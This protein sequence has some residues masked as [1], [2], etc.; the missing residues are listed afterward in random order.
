MMK[1]FAYPLRAAI[2][3][4]RL[5]VLAQAIGAVCLLW[6]A[7]GVVAEPSQTPLLQR[8]ESNP[9][10]N[11]LFSL[12]DSGSMTHQYVP[13]GKF[14]VNDTELNFPKDARIYMHPLELAKNIWSKNGNKTAPQ[15][16]TRFVTAVPQS[17]TSELT[18][19]ERRY[20][21]QMRSPQ[22]NKLY[23]NPAFVYAPW[24]GIR[25]SN[26]PAGSTA[27]FQKGDPYTFTAATYTAAKLDPMALDQET[28]L[29]RN[30]D[31]THVKVFGTAV[32]LSEVKSY[33][34]YWSNKAF[35]NI[36][37]TTAATMVNGNIV[38]ANVSS[39]LTSK[40]YNPGLV[41]VLRDGG[42]PT[43]LSDYK[44][45]NLNATATNVVYDKAYSQ[46][47]ELGGCVANADNKT[48]CPIDVERQ[49]FANWFVFYRSR[50]MAAQGGIPAALNDFDRVFRFGW[51]TLRPGVLFDTKDPDND[52]NITKLAKSYLDYNKDGGYYTVD[53]G[54]SATVQYG[55]RDWEA[56]RKR[57]FMQWLRSLNTWGGTPT[58]QAVYSVGEYFKRSSPWLSD[59]SVGDN[60]GGTELSCRR[61]YHMVMTDGYYTE[62]TA[63]DAA[64]GNLDGAKKTDTAGA[65]STDYLYPTP[66][67]DGAGD[68]LA[69]YVMKYWAT[70][71]RANT[72]NAVNPVTVTPL[73]DTNDA[74]AVAEAKSDPA[75][76]QH[77][78]HFFLGFGVT[79]NKLSNAA[80][81]D[82]TAYDQ[83]LLKMIHCGQ[84]GG[85]CWDDTNVDRVD[86][87][88]HASLNGRGSYFSVNN[89]DDV[90]NAVKSIVRSLNPY[91]FKEAGV[92]TAS[93]S[94]QA[95]NVKFVPEY[96]PQS[97][98]ID[99]DEYWT[100]DVVAW[101][102]DAKGVAAATPLWKAS[103]SLPAPASRNIK[104]LD[105]NT[106]VDFK[107]ETYTAL[108]ADLI[109]FVRGERPS[110]YFRK[111]QNL[112]PDFI[113]ST[114]LFINKGN[115]LGYGSL[116]TPFTGSSTY[117][118][119]LLGTKATTG[120]ARNNDG[121]A[122]RNDGLL[123]VGGNGGMLHAFST[124]TGEE[125]FAYVPRGAQENQSLLSS[126]N[127]GSSS[128]YH[129]FFVDG[130]L[131]E[132]DAYFG[133]KWHNIVVGTL[134][135]GGRG[136]FALDLKPS[137]ISGSDAVD[138]LWD[139]KPTPDMG[140][141]TSTPQVGR[142]ADGSW[143]VFIG[144]GVDS[145]NNTPS[146]TVI[147]LATGESQAIAVGALPTSTAT[148][149]TTADN[150][151][152]SSKGLGGVTL[153]RDTNTGNVQAI[154]AG[155][156]DGRLW[157]F[158][159]I[160]DGAAGSTTTSIKAAFG[161]VP[162]FTA[163]D[164]DS[165]GKPQPILAA[166]AIFAHPQGG[167]VIVVNTGKL[168]HEGDNK[169]SQQLQSV[170]GIWDQQPVATDT[171]T[172][173]PPVIGRNDL[174]H[175]LIDKR[176]D[177]PQK[178]GPSQAFFQLKT[179][180][181]DWNSQQGW[182]LDLNVPLTTLANTGY[183]HPKAIYD[184]VIFRNSVLI[185]AVSPGST[186]ETC[187][188]STGLG[189][190]LL[191]KGLTGVVSSV[192]V[193]DT[194]GDGVV[195]NDDQSGV[196]GL[197]YSGGRSTILTDGGCCGTTNPPIPPSPNDCLNG[198]DQFADG[199]RAIRDC[200]G[201]RIQDR[202]WRQLLN[203]PQVTTVD[204]S[205][206]GTGTGTTSTTTSTSTSTATQ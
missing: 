196:G 63:K 27:S 153:V 156:T 197:T 84:A 68:T 182:L 179:A 53:G 98:A 135:A 18:D 78:N 64:V 31:D 158:D 151:T 201:L 69:D 193:I 6:H 49:N 52:P 110:V 37:V 204:T 42:D 184:P 118:D 113:N 30:A 121:K 198:S 133:D 61:A 167:Q 108:D 191:L 122:S 36:D 66:F 71:L 4:P 40:T 96:S 28:P 1:T 11:F 51:G 23:Y 125:R 79:A 203:P 120:A 166:P 111:R 50:L 136:I 41:Y 116:K 92:A 188:K 138:V 2:T 48:S 101:S 174:Q 178:T 91:P 123:F 165:G 58:R 44:E 90:K 95:G 24:P 73:S 74:K 172:M 93:A 102:L 154:Y 94:L 152:A 43:V 70:D 112:L 46:R 76:W 106:L 60:V 21:Y 128:N 87:L 177:L 130:Q 99:F 86:D 163:T 77:L 168:L 3:A 147:D 206:T 205:K 57:Q 104:V 145:D 20:Q 144:N 22:V 39:I 129:H 173:T 169:G 35:N 146:L 80:L 54:S 45:F 170:Y 199:S 143:R 115:D 9:K 159:V 142:L 192:P 107:P 16:D 109:R 97:K 185:N 5:R 14:F 17:V 200:G 140:Y 13:E 194:N 117:Q 75:T 189:Y 59:P 33:T 127:Y 148:T 67:H 149:S 186:E 181:V 7:G 180:K 141:M 85:L 114:P 19:D 175:Q 100:G 190:S 62:L 81:T 29:I 171:A 139:K 124:T 15:V 195:N 176:L 150:S 134:G 161:G 82:P 105:G 187:V 131:A 202:I 56:G 34:A 83:D 25:G 72:A 119:Y 155:D 65:V 137:S 164:A 183:D 89:V 103:A 126:P 47:I 160:N 10:A 32:D 132:S 55:V 12:D 157:R 26:S 38:P 162:L 88:W 8:P